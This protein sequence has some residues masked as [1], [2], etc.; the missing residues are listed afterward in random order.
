MLSDEEIV[1]RI[2]VSF[3]EILSDKELNDMYNFVQSSAYEKLFKSG[4]LFKAISIQ[5]S[6]INDE[7]DNI[8][9]N[10]SEQVERP[11]NRFKPIPI[12]K[13]MDF[14]LLLIT[15]IRWKV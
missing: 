3:D 10:F 11:S 15:I 14:T 12:D 7:I 8:T 1:K 13:E 2:S 4:E 9:K 5:F 6:D